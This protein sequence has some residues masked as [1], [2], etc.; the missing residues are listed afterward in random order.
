MLV[1]SFD[2]KRL[3]DG[4]EHVIANLLAAHFLLFFF[5][6]WNATLS[7]LQNKCTARHT[8]TGTQTQTK[9]YMGLV[10]KLSTGGTISS[11]L[12]AATVAG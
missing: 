8:D 5:F 1:F 6:S 7:N 2:S 10:C 3:A 11:L 12:S 4:T 9:D